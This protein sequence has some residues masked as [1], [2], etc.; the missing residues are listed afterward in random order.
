MPMSRLCAGKRS[1]LAVAQDLASVRPEEAGHGR[2][3]VGLPAAARPQQRENSPP[4][5]VSETPA[6]AQRRVVLVQLV[7]PKNGPMA[8]RLVPNRMLKKTRSCPG[9]S[10]RSTRKAERD[11]RREGTYHVRRSAARARQ[12]RRWAF[13]SN[14]LD[15]GHGAPPMTQF[16]RQ[17]RIMK[18]PPAAVWMP[19]AAPEVAVCSHL[20]IDHHGKWWTRHR[21]TKMVALISV[22]VWTPRQ[23]PPRHDPRQHQTGGDLGKALQ[24]GHTPS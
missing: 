22:I 6:S 21:N 9:C 23:N 10:K 7:D 20:P 1:T 11:A 5:I 13:F 8:P 14:L 19:A 15:R 2:S 17:D 24:R 4:W 12:R 16:H 3:S 18:T